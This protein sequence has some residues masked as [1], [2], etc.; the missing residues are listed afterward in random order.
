MGRARVV[1]RKLPVHRRIKERDWALIED[2]TKEGFYEVGTL[3]TYEYDVKAIEIKLAEGNE[4]LD[5]CLRIGLNEFR[6]SRLYA[7]KKIP[8]DAAQK[9]YDWRIREMFR[10]DTVY[11]ACFPDG[12]VVG[13]V[14]LFGLDKHLEINLIAVSSDYQR[15]GV[16]TLLVN[17]SI[18]ECK[19]RGLNTLKV[20]TQG[21][22][23]PSRFLYEKMGFKH[24]KLERDFHKHANIID[25]I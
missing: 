8:F 3:Y 7:D 2:A 18:D 10:T 4:H 22:N 1:N 25:R 6:H 21:S 13:F 19:R 20:K 15:Q 24:T 9:I 11:V 16:G 17:A 5:D 12:T 14:S 23:Q